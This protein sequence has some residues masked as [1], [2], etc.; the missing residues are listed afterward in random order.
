[1]ENQEIKAL[2]KVLL[3]MKGCE[4]L[5]SLE[6]S[7][8]TICCDVCDKS[9]HCNVSRE[10]IIKKANFKNPKKIL[11]TLISNGFIKEYPTRGSMTYTITKD[12][13]ECVN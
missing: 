7:L 4:E 10:K 6:L 1:M 11:Q 5:N 8:L 2:L 12:G 9:P 3:I 13:I